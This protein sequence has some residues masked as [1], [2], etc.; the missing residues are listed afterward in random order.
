MNCKCDYVYVYR[1]N[2]SS[3]EQK[4]TWSL[5]HVNFRFAHALFVNPIEMLPW[6]LL[7]KD[8]VSAFILGVLQ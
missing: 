7:S 8:K 3:T 1:E 2:Y 5:L 4:V 6:L